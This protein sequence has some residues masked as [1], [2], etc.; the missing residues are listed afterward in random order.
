MGERVHPATGRH[1]IYFVC[2]FVAGEPTIDDHEEV[3]AAVLGKG[4]GERELLTLPHE[5]AAALGPG[6]RSAVWS[7]D[8]CS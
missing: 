2:R 6:S 1:L 4:D 5:T 7:L 3:A 8:R